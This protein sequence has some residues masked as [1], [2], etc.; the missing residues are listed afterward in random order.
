MRTTPRYL[1]MLAAAALVA[2]VPAFADA[3][4]ANAATLPAPAPGSEVYLRPA[5]RVFDVVGGGYGHGIGMSQYG[6]QGAATKGL[7]HSEIL[8]FYYPGT[9]IAQTTLTTIKIGITI[10]ND[11]VVQVGARPGLAMATG[12]GK[13]LALPPEPTQWKVTATGK[14]AT[15]CVVES[16]QNSKW[17]VYQKDKTPCP[18]TFSSTQAT[19]SVGQAKSTVDLFLPGGERRVYR[20]TITAEHTGTTKLVTVNAL[21]MEDYLRGVVPSEMPPSWQLEALKSQAVAARTY[22]STRSKHT[23]YY[24]TCD[25]TSCQV[26]KGRG[27]RKPDGTITSYE[28]GSTN[29]AID[30]TP[31]EVLNFKFPDGVRLATTMYS[32]SNGG[33]AVAA[34]GDHKYLPAKDDPYDGAYAGGRPHA[35]NA[36]LPVAALESYFGIARVERIQILKRDGSGDW[37][38]RVQSVRVEGFTSTGAYVSKD[39][40]GN[41]IMGVRPWPSYSDGLSSNYFTINAKAADPGTVSP[42]TISRVAGSDRFSTAAEAS[43]AFSPGVDVVYVASGSDFPDALAGAARAAYYGG[44]LLLTQTNAVPTATRDAMNRLRPT[45]VV[46][47][48]GTG[49]VSDSV[50]KSLQAMTTGRALQRV[51]GSNRYDTAALIAGYYP[52][53]GKVAYVATGEDFPDALAGAALAGRDKAPV[54]LTKPTSVPAA[55]AKALSTLRPDRI[56]VLGSTGAVSAGVASQLARYTSTGSVTRLA[57]SDRYGTAAAVAKQFST[58]TSV[59]VPSGENFPDALAAAAVAGS[60]GAPVLLTR[61]DRLPDAIRDE[62][63]RLKPQSAYVLGGPTVVSN[64]VVAKVRDA[65]N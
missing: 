11:G 20:G 4:T 44:P 1:A 22:A 14:T 13:A 16:Y 43:R 57:G 50:A 34:G 30:A 7:K 64:T 45:R 6:A 49:A 41:G 62:L 47:L 60:F 2:A 33:R 17:S 32:S 10:D 25:T 55:T 28:W 19:E 35:W 59:Y 42:G 27:A 48:G 37:G 12:G 24:D 40:S 39:T 3:P 9:T 18:V 65:I 8:S 52:P 46:V 63:V 23:S 51:G 38:G 29:A 21:P 31:G 56:V 15:T 5:D 54:L 26:Y 58:A 53:R 61:S 36:K